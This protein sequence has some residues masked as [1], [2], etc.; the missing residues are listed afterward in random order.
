MTFARELQRLFP[1]RRIALVKYSRGGTS[2]AEDAAGRFGCWEPDVEQGGDTTGSVNQYGYSDTWHHD[3]AGSIDLGRA[4][5][6]AMAS[7]LE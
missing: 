3:S 5:A 6:E 7:M 2:I 4:F 1:D